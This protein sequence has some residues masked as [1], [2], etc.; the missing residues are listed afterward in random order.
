MHLNHLVTFVICLPL[1]VTFSCRNRANADTFLAQRDG[2]ISGG[3]EQV[4]RYES[5]KGNALVQGIRPLRDGE[6][7][8]TTTVKIEGEAAALMYKRLDVREVE[9]V[10]VVNQGQYFVKESDLTC[11]K[12]VLFEIEGRKA[13]IDYSCGVVV[14]NTGKIKAPDPVVE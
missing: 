12:V 1:L 11:T 14:L 6:P 8:S 7:H 4:A 5:A 10:G 3:G 9:R 2:T 13:S